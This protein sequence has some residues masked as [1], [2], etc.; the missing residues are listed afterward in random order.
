MI[1]FFGVIIL[2]VTVALSGGA[3]Y[4]NI[5]ENSDLERLMP[6]KLV[7]TPR[8]RLHLHC[9]GKGDKT[10]MLLSGM[11]GSFLVWKTVQNA[12]ASSYQVCSYDRAG[13][14][15]SDPSTVDNNAETVAKNLKYLLDKEN[16]DRIVLVGHS[17]GGII[18]RSFHA[19]DP[20]KVIGMVLVDASHE[21]QGH[22]VP[23]FRGIPYL[24][25]VP[26][27]VKACPY[28]AKVGIL[29]IIDHYESFIDRNALPESIAEQLLAMN[30]RSSY[31]RGLQHE[32]EGFLNSQ[33]TN[34]S[35]ESLGNLP[36]T[37]IYRDF[38]E[39]EIAGMTVD[40]IYARQLK[41]VWL[42]LQEELAQL[43]SN[44]KLL[45]AKDSGHNIPYDQ[46]QWVIGA[47]EE[48]VERLDKS[49]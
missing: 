17:F 42:E 36:L 13:V 40:D 29:R 4:Q 8:G 5:S 18:A 1:K 46:P 49:E 22:R 9:T 16:I 11:T 27:D 25:Y 41:T 12:L 6:G 47:V 3:I 24:P 45:L 39:Q 33:Q 26:S 32:I 20:Q 10:I 37:V 35:L 44:S 23:Y 7:D 31:C 19:L 15:W 2:V 21:Q 34:E 48:L 30:Y 43:S 14:G 28:V 38:F